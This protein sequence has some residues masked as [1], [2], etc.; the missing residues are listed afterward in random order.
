MKH[1]PF[2]NV[3]KSIEK[4]YITK[5]NTTMKALFPLPLKTMLAVLLLLIAV[6]CDNQQESV[7]LEFEEVFPNDFY[8]AII[9]LTPEIDDS[10]V[11]FKGEILTMEDLDNVK[12]GFM[13]YILENVTGDVTT[14]EVGETGVAQVFS[15]E[16]E[17]LPTNITLVVCA[18]IEGDEIG[19]IIANEEEFVVP[20]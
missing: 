7:F 17:N 13:W 12:Y 20:Q 5:T 6:S 4:N 3:I 14:L 16:I 1:H 11:A 8:N 19:T 2:S 18:Y 15:L 9:T 10:G